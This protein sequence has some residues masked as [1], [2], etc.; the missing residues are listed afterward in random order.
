MAKQREGW[1]VQWFSDPAEADAQVYRHYSSMTP[2][3]RLDEMA[4]LLNRY[5]NWNERRLTRVARIVTVPRG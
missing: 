2:Q 1:A 3:Q 5:A 4:E